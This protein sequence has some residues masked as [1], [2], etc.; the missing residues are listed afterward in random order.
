VIDIKKPVIFFDDRGKTHAQLEMVEVFHESFAHLVFCSARWQNENDTHYG[1]LFNRHTGEVLN[2]EFEHW[3]AHNPQEVPTVKQRS[4]LPTMDDVARQQLDKE[5]E[6]IERI[7]AAIKQEQKR[8]ASVRM[9]LLDW[10]S[11]YYDTVEIYDSDYHQG[12]FPLQAAGR[13]NFRPIRIRNYPHPLGETV[14]K[15]TV[16]GFEFSNVF[17]YQLDNDVTTCTITDFKAVE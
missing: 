12:R 8:L 14:P 1:I 6:R 9:E 4:S 2:A 15:L 7:V 17:G 16:A 13:K 11:S 10:P 5:N 3:L